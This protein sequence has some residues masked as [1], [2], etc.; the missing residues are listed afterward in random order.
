MLLMSTL[1]VPEL[2]RLEPLSTICKLILS[3]SG[4]SSPRSSTLKGC[5]GLGCEGD[6]IHVLTAGQGSA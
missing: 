2:I 4:K 6:M 1:Q 5:P 3:P